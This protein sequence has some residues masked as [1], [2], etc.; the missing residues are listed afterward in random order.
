ME[1]RKELIAVAQTPS[2]GVNATP[3]D[4]SDA[5]TSVPPP[6]TPIRSRSA[7]I[8]AVETAE[9]RLNKALFLSSDEDDENE[10]DEEEQ[11]HRKGAG[12][13]YSHDSNSSSRSAE[14]QAFGGAFRHRTR[15]MDRLNMYVK[16]D[17]PSHAVVCFAIGGGNVYFDSNLLMQ[18]IAVLE[19]L[20]AS[21]RNFDN[22]TLPEIYLWSILRDVANGLKVLHSHEIVHLDLKPDNIFITERGRLKL[23]DFGMAG[24]VVTMSASSG[25]TGD[26]EGDAK[27]MAKELLSSAERLPSADIFCLG[28]TMLEI[29]TG[30]T[31]PSAGDQWHALRQGSLPL[32][33]S[34]YSKEL[35]SLIRQLRG[36]WRGGDTDAPGGFVCALRSCARFPVKFNST[37]SSSRRK[38]RKAHFGAHST[39]RRVIMSA[40]LSKDLQNKYNV[41]YLPI[42]KEDE[43]TIVRGSFKGREGRVTAVYRKK[44]VIHVERVV[45]EKANGASVPIGIDAS[46]VIISKLKLDKDRKKILERK[47]RAVGE[48]SKGK[49]T[50]QDVAM[51]TVD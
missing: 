2:S 5:A 49:F 18:E 31:L 41:S 47:N 17:P 48:A 43:V 38:S 40:S 21:Q 24:K 50:E 7:D 14:D 20:T 27:Y 6:S 35:G 10:E 42:R 28:I 23:G 26:L 19:K 44:F 15:R 51:A 34:E 4:L 33:P 16:Q 45:R 29:A 12:R 11:D 36:I 8:A 32:L 37:V 22:I 39:Q 3:T 46:K 25:R 13:R 9:P 1:E 30:V